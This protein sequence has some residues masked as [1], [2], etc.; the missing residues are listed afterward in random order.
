MRILN[1]SAFGLTCAMTLWSTTALAEATDQGA[2]ALLAVFQTYLGTT[3]GVVTVAVGGDAYQVT[4]DAAHLMAEVPAE[5]GMTATISPVV[6]TLTDN[7][8]GTWEYEVD[9]PVSIFYDFPGAMTTKTEYEQVLLTG[10]FDEALGDSSAYS[11]AMNN[12]LTEQTQGD[13]TLGEIVMKVTQDSATIEGT[14][15]PGAAGGVDG[16]F[17]T[18]S[19]NLRYEMTIAGGEGM[20]PMPFVLTVAEGGAE[21]V[22]TGYQPKGLYGLLAYFVAHPDAVMIEADAAGLKS[23][24]EAAL[25][26]FANL[27]MTGAYK[28]LTLETPM[29]P[30]GMDEAGLT[31]DMNGAVAEGKFREAISIKGLTLPEDLVPPFAAAMVPTDLTLDVAATRFD[32]AAGAALGLG[33]LDLTADATPGPEFGAQLLSAILPEGSLDITIAPGETNAPGYRRTYEGSMA[34]GPAMPM[35]VGKARIGLTGMDKIN[36]AILESPPEMGLQ[37]MGMML[38]MAQMMSQPGVDGEL[39]WEIEATEAG[40]LLINGQD[41]M[42]G[43]Q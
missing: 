24:L 11:I 28:T 3:E 33:L 10:T 9:Q 19:G 35:P 26:I 30:V 14:A 16:Q 22:M 8:D 7:G 40:G 1:T 34:V 15:Q 42:G 31:I 18:S 17:T 6:M 43:G 2:A 29:G 27:Q 21:V 25:P 23:A 13:P 37:E 12:M 5:V 20:P 41:M 36:E 4:L 32:L 38:G 39:I